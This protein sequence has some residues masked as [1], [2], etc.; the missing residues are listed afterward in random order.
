MKWMSIDHKL[1][2]VR[3]WVVVGFMKMS[4]KNG[5]AE[6]IPQL[7]WFIAQW[8]GKQWCYF[9]DNHTSDEQHGFMDGKYCARFARSGIITHWADL[10][11]IIEEDDDIPTYWAA[12]IDEDEDEDYE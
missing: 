4:K 6:K 3:R 2:P 12:P 1:P 7:I 9:N 10:G 8:T 5:A 11:N